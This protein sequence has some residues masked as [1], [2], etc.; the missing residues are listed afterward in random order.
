MGAL[1]EEAV[2]L[3][4]EVE[5]GKSGGI[6][7]EE[8]KMTPG[9]RFVTFE[10]AQHESVAFGELDAQYPQRPC[11]LVEYPQFCC[12]FSSPV[13]HAP[14]SESLGK[15]QSVKSALIWSMNPAR[16][17]PHRS[18]LMAIPSSLVACWAY[19]SSVSTQHQRF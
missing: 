18:L 17:V 3:D 2:G 16:G 13:I 19:Y 15:A 7:V 10:A 1:L 14:L 11:R 8:G 9:H 5:D 6:E 12:S 4:V